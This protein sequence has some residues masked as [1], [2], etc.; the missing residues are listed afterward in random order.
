[1]SLNSGI[2][3]GTLPKYI[4]FYGH[5]HNI[6]AKYSQSMIRAMVVRLPYMENPL[7]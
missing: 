6:H 7:K 1:M 5:H 2:R 4:K 3:F